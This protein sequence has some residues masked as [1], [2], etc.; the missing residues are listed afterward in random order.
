M[1][2][3]FEKLNS[4]SG[5]I[6]KQSEQLSYFR[7]MRLGLRIKNTNIRI[8]FLFS[9]LYLIENIHWIL[10]VL[11]CSTFLNIRLPGAR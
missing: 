6:K 10:F 9:Y 3:E 4:Y 1:Q 11:N 5:T 2:D 8:F 7:I